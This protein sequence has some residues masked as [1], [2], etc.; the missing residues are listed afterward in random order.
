MAYLLVAV[1]APAR[2]RSGAGDIRKARLAAERGAQERPASSAA[3]VA[4]GEAY[5]QSAR[6]ALDRHQ[7]E[8]RYL[9]F[10][11]RS[12]EACVKAARLDPEN[13][14]PHFFLAVIDAYR[15]DLVAALRGFRNVENLRS[16][17]V[18]KTNIAE[19]YIY[20][21]DL[22]AAR[23]WNQRGLA[24]DAGPGPVA[25]NDMLIHWKDGDLAGA[26]R[27]FRRLHAEHPEMIQTINVARLPVDLGSFEKFTEYC[28]GSPACGPY[29]EEACGRAGFEVEQR[30]ISEEGQREELR[31]E[32]EKQWELEGI[33]RNRRDLLFSV[34]PSTAR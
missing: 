11:G 12:V 32:M 33:Y 16:S 15:G 34:D 21:G 5:Y 17:G 27:L 30:K 29:M 9:I 6:D 14:R 18:A 13:D 23:V 24:D 2:G 19:I 8:T 1:A 28:C 4:L 26:R 22:E 10:L 20:M 3:Q 7:D 25:F 31:I